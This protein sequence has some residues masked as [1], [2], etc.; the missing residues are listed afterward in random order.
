MNKTERRA[1]RWL[2]AT[3]N[4][5]AKDIIFRSHLSPDFLLPDGSGV[6]VK[7]FTSFNLNIPFTQWQQLKECHPCSIAVFK[8]SRI[9][10]IV[11]PF[12]MLQVGK[13]NRLGDYTINLLPDPN[14]GQHFYSEVLDKIRGCGLSGKAFWAEYRRVSKILK[15]YRDD[16]EHQAASS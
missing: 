13:N 15:R 11:I 2:V 6:E 4:F 3:T 1:L 9:P 7:R 12:E 10:D 5:R 8:D 16:S 14:E